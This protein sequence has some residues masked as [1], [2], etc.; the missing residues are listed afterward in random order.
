M[1]GKRSRN[2][3]VK[4]MRGQ[5][6][7]VGW[8][9]RPHSFSSKQVR[10]IKEEKAQNSLA[11]ADTYRNIGF[12]SCNQGKY[13]EALYWYHKERVIKEEKAPNIDLAA[14]YHCI[15][16]TFYTQGKCDE[17]LE[18]YHKERLIKEEKAPNSQHQQTGSRTAL[19]LR[20]RTT[21]S[22]RHATIRACAMRHWHRTNKAHL[23]REQPQQ[24]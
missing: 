17:A 9:R 15:G 3:Y 11:L 20:R 2:L 7:G 4:S 23:T 18:W 13:D 16:Y 22:E 24:P 10:L 19:I 14:T 6:V 8:E 1:T 21:P 5:G 12:V